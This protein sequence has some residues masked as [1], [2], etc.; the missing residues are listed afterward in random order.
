M[1][2]TDLKQNSGPKLIGKKYCANCSLTQIEEYMY[3]YTP[4]I[5]EQCPATFSATDG[6]AVVC[7]GFP[8]TIFGS[9]KCPY[10]EFLCV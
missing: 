3:I 6:D 9:T 1:C 4:S 8:W 5:T 10:T 7:G 2:S